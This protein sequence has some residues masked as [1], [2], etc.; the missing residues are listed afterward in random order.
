MASSLNDLDGA[1][2]AQEWLAF[3]NLLQYTHLTA[4]S[5]LLVTRMN[6]RKRAKSETITLRVDPK[7]K[8]M[9]EFLARLDSQ[10]I[11]AVVDAAIRERADSRG[12]QVD[13]DSLNHVAVVRYWSEFW[14]PSE[15]IRSLKLLAEQNYNSNAEEDEIRQFALSHWQFFYTDP[16]GQN[17]RRA[18]V[19]ILWPSLPHL[20]ELWHK[21]K[22][23][24]YWVAGKEIKKI[25]TAA[26]I[27]SPAWPP[28]TE[29][30]ARPPTNDLD[31]DIPF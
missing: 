27:A 26:G 3:G 22:C 16:E 1:N 24:D 14:D 17:P 9:I 19:D 21:Q 25:L 13:Y 4:T 7:T 15:G 2:C 10:T 20:I 30:S 31:D 29:I 23:V 6:E 12:I 5:S 28:K 18:F 11:T 8:F